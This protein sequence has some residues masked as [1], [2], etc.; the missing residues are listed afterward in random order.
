MHPFNDSGGG[1]LTNKFF[2]SSKNNACQEARKVAE[3]SKDLSKSNVI[4]CDTN[5]L[6]IDKI[7][8]NESLTVY[9]QNMHSLAKKTSV[10]SC[11]VLANSYDII[12][13]TETWMNNS[14]FDAEFFDTRYGVLRQDRN[15][16][17]TGKVRGRGVLIAT[18]KDLNMCL[19]DSCDEG[20]ECVIAKIT[21]GP[22]VIYICVVYLAPNSD[23]DLYS[24]FFNRVETHCQQGSTILLT[25]DFN[26]P[27]IEGIDFDFAS[28]S[29]KCQLLWNFLSYYDIKSLNHVVNN[30]K[31]TL[32]LVLSNIDDTTINR[33]VHPLISED[34]HHPALIITITIPKCKKNKTKSN[35]T[36]YNFNRADFEKLYRDLAEANWDSLKTCTDVNAMVEEFYRIIY[37]IMDKCVPRRKTFKTTYP[38]WFNK[39]IIQKIK[40]KSKHH[41]KV[42][43]GGGEFHVKEFNKLRAE[44]KKDIRRAYKEYILTSESNIHDNPSELWNFLKSKTKHLPVGHLT[45]EEQK[46]KNNE[47]ISNT[48]A[49]YFQSQLTKS[50]KFHDRDNDKFDTYTSNQ[51][52]VLHISQIC[53]TEIDNAIKLLKPKRSVGPDG[54]PPYIIK[55]CADLLKEPLYF[56][57]NMSLKT[58]TFPDR[59][60]LAL[61]CPIPKEG[62]T[63]RIEN[64]RP[65]ALLSAFA[66]VFEQILFQRIQKYVKPVISI[67]QHGFVQQKSTATNLSIITDVV[68]KT[69]DQGKQVDVIYIDFEKAFDKVDHGI[70]LAKLRQFHFS[71]NLID[72]L[73]SY[74]QNRKQCVLY[75]DFIS[76]QYTVL[77]G[78]PQGS[79][80]GP[81]MFLLFINDLPDYIL[82]SGK[83][84]FAD[85]FKIYTPIDTLNDCILLQQSLDNVLAWCN[86]NK[87]SVNINK[88][89]ILSFT[90]N[91]SVVQYPYVI[92]ETLL[93]RPKLVKDLGVTF[94]SKL[95]FN[96]HVIKITNEAYKM[97]GLIIRLGKDFSNKETFISLFNSYVRSKLE[98]AT[99]V[100]N[101]IT[102]TNRRKLEIIQAK[103]LRY[104]T[105][106]ETKMYPTYDNH[107]TLAKNF[108]MLTLQQRRSLQDLL[109]LHKILHNKIDCVDLIANFYFRIPSLKTRNQKYGPFF[110]ETARTKSSMLSP[111]RRISASYNEISNIKGDIDI[112]STEYKTFKTMIIDYL[113]NL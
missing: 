9:Y 48:F 22:N 17:K 42:R 11:N 29:S 110:N 80:L 21:S 4:L 87:L 60:K 71:P 53:M 106:K 96:D 58:H 50:P 51:L 84:L 33:A 23:I 90:K 76:K 34:I 78:V 99:I 81:L 69:L 30:H 62:N 52:D 102:E 67:H 32:D 95:T 36:G 10:F 37:E 88:C 5:N 104:L 74:L 7:D 59:W 112:F 94:D 79:N 46:L 57:Y 12:I 73:S 55:G 66:K 54:I 86:T 39:D 49:E 72:F 31:R 107:K 2:L 15:L 38:C 77:S 92:N 27:E 28:A 75:K 41:S 108:N 1:R 18:L 26:L 97:L 98:H 19:L 105:F 82:H 35:V 113:S 70:L 61:V 24:N 45:F 8:R 89:K 6:Q 63:T 109:F 20:Y 13:A 111:F 40:M 64:H 43:K 47:E 14:H 56:L 91:K 103:F 16:N 101:P 83:L 65:I 85:D 68:A 93:P 25:G 100:W 44:I 3:D